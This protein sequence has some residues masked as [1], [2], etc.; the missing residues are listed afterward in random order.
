MIDC[1]GDLDIEGSAAEP[2]AEKL[3]RTAHDIKTGGNRHDAISV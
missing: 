1:C 3:P 2:G